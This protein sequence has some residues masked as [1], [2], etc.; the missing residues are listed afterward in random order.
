MVPD[1]H[2]LY[3]FIGE[4]FLWVA[5]SIFGGWLWMCPFVLVELHGKYS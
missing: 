1:E 5:E 4:P 3:M 2:F